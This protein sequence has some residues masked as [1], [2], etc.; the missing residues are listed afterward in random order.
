MLLPHLLNPLQHNI[1]TNI[2]QQ[3]QGQAQS[4]T[5][6]QESG[7]SQPQAQ[8]Q[9]HSH[10]HVRQGPTRLQFIVPGEQVDLYG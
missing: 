3:Q 10:A 8:S 5:P 4:Q 9:Q 7:G 1:R 6:S 2:M